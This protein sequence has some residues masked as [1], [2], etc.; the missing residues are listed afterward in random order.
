MTTLAQLRD[1]L[2]NLEQVVPEEHRHAV[3]K[4]QNKV[5]YTAPEMAGMRWHETHA[6]LV[7]ITPDTGAPDWADQ[8]AEVWNRANQESSTN[9]A[10]GSSLA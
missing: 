2:R 10:P 1:V 3:A 5:Q 4:M 9:I 6:M 7:K 8:A